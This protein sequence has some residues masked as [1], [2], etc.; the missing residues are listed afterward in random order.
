MH[1]WFCLAWLWVA[2]GLWAADP[3]HLLLITVD[4]MNFDSVGVYG[5]QVPQTTPNIDRL[6]SEG[7]RFAHGH[8]TI[9][10]CQ[11]T[12]AVWM[13]GRYPHNSGAFGFDQ[14][15]PGVP[16]LPETLKRHGYTTGILGKTEHVI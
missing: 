1:K 12:R 13:T 16:T 10:I 8:V 6:A 11:P 7:M 3:V 4:D 5:C 2:S 9:A 15:R 14:I